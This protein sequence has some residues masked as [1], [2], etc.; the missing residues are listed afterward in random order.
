MCH[1]TLA[2]FSS[3]QVD[4]TLIFHCHNDGKESWKQECRRRAAGQDTMS[5]SDRSLVIKKC[6]TVTETGSQATG[7]E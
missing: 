3:S 6:E 7:T 2:Y 4:V 1:L 5:S